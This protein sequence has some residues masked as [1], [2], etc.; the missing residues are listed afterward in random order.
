M[1]APKSFS[2]ILITGASGFVGLHL[3]LAALKKGYTVRTTVRSA[4]REAGVRQALAAL[5]NT[6]GLEFAHADLLADAGWEDAVRGC[7]S[8][9]HTAAPYT[10]D[11]PRDESIL[12]APAVDGTMRVLTAAARAGIRRVVLLST[13]GAIF[14]GHEG[15]EKVFT[16]AD[17]S[18]VD[19]PRVIYH[20][21]KTLAERAAW[22]FINSAENS[23]GMEMVSVN[24]S[25]VMGPVLDEHVHTSTEWYRTLMHAQVPGVSNSQLDLVDVRDLADILLRAMML[26]QAAGKRFICSGASIPLLEFANIL[27]ENFADR[28]FHIPHKLIPDLVIRFFGLFSPKI[29]AVARTNNWKYGFSTARIESTFGWQP[30]PYQQTIIEMA[31]SLIKFGLV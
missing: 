20:K 24:P 9:I 10:A 14:D 22:N 8:V 4:A 28:G 27:Y 12:I 1:T 3:T 2:K 15:E 21:A 13:I 26:P 25:N 31:E 6:T 29:K 18:N 19:K 5:V 23:P 11:N 7:D 16:E 17:W 30:R